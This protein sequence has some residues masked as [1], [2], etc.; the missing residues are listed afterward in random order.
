MEYKELEYLR[1]H[2]F[3][4]PFKKM[5]VVAL[6]EDAEQYAAMMRKFEKCNPG[7]DY[8]EADE[9]EYEYRFRSWARSLL[10]LWIE[11]GWNQCLDEFALEMLHAAMEDKKKL[12]R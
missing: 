1:K 4:N 12:V 10:Y 9:L 11:Y 6:R 3:I 8:S 7:I 2:T 5:K